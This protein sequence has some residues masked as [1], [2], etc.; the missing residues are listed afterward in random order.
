MHQH[1]TRH[2]TRATPEMASI[3]V[4]H[5]TS[6]AATEYRPARFIALRCPR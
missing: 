6:A 4:D 5:L 2:G 1:G 3:T